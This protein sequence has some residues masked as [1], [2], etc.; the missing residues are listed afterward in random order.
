MRSLLA[1]VALVG[2][3]FAAPAW[4]E[5]PRVQQI[6]D[7]MANDRLLTARRIAEELL[8]EDPDSVT[9]NWAIGVAYRDEDGNLPRAMHHLGTARKL[10]E[11]GGASEAEIHPDFHRALLHTIA[12]TA[13]DMEEYEYQLALLDFHDSRY[14]P[15]LTAEHAWPLMKL[16]RLDEARAYALEASASGDPWQRSQGWNVRCA[17]EAEA[18]DRQ[19]GWEAC[20]GALE[21]ARRDAEG[22]VN[23]DAYN[24]SLAA[25]TVLRFEE[26][27]ALARE[28]ATGGPMSTANPHALLLGMKLAAGRGA[29]AVEAL[30]ELQAWRARQPPHLR[31]QNR[32]ELDGQIA[33]LFLVAGDTPKAMRLA[34]RALQY[35]DR[36]A[37]T[38]EDADQSLARHT[39]L[40]L[41]A[42]AAWRE[43]AAERASAGG[44]WER[45]W[46][47]LASWLPDT[48]Q[49][50]DR[51]TL[52]A[53]LANRR[54]LESSFRPYLPGGVGAPTWEMG[55][56]FSAVG[57]G[58]ASTTL[59]QARMS[60]QIPGFQPWYDAWEAEVAW[61]RRDWAGAIALAEQ[62]RA[63]L[64][65]QEQLLRA[66]LAGIAAD[67]ARRQWDT[68]GE[69]AWLEEALREDGS[70]IRRL[71]LSIPVRVEVEAEGAAAAAAGRMLARSPRHRSSS[72]AFVLVVQGGEDQ[73]SSCLRNAT[74]AQIVCAPL[75]RPPPEV[76]PESGE[77][78]PPISDWEYGR[79]VAW[80]WHDRAFAM[81][82]GA[83]RIDLRSLD[84]ATTA[85]S[86]RARARMNEV[87]QG[88]AEGR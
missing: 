14:D 38:S 46:A 13:A 75:P 56:L 86:E 66:R 76:D 19:L 32:A 17:L 24:A 80:A 55:P 78:Q 20:R 69:I 29:E 2:L 9:A 1:I 40:R 71:G 16:G 3:A 42:R 81:P 73:L 54:L 60:E 83:S 4:A 53:I 47:W 82:V 41:A 25:R 87:L 27:E 33:W 64:P 50:A 36:R 26:A 44:F 88:T 67:C 11:Q 21:E 65:P 84:G 77:A 18:Q 58:V 59:A 12:M 52:A 30:R 39:A 22:D 37:S 61:H 72:G 51:A 79:L 43:Q 85:D 5:D 34:N 6:A 15:N 74:G 49:R 8:A 63:S 31:Q 10:V 70:L 57:P 23:V 35:P 7:A 62:A 45:S 28:S 68:A 48:A